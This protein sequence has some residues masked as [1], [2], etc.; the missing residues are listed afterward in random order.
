[1][2]V[3][4]VGVVVGPG[5]VISPVVVAEAYVWILLPAVPG[6]PVLLAAAVTRLE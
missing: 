2:P 6:Y 3:A 4:D 1:M 5:V